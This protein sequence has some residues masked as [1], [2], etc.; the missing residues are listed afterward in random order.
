[1][2]EITTTS[3]SMLPHLRELAATTRRNIEQEWERERR[4]RIDH[5]AQLAVRLADDQI[6][7]EFPATIARVL[8][9]EAWQ[10]Y[11]AL[12]LDGA[13]CEWAIGPCAVAHLGEGLWLHHTIVPGTSRLSEPR[14]TLIVAC[15]CGDYREV[16]VSD[17]YQFARELQHIDDHRDVCLDDCTPN[18]LPPST[19]TLRDVADSEEGAA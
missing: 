15:A 6:H 3:V 19:E 9:P 10:G 2:T 4:E 5:Q 17:D 16:T 8:D 12:Y 7:T 11:P 14:W 13:E 18:D 1:M